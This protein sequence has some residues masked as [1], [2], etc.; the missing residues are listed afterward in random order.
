MKI[1]VLSLL[2]L[3]DV[4]MT[5]PTF[6]GIREKYP[7]AELHVLMNQQFKSVEPLIPFVDEFKYF[8]RNQLQKG[9]GEAN[10]NIFDSFERLSLLINELNAEKYDLV[11]NLTHNYLSAWLMGLIE[12][13]SGKIGLEFDEFKKTHLNSTWFE[14]FNQHS[15]KYSPALFHFSDVYYYGSQLP[16]KYHP[17]TLQETERGKKEALPY[18][19]DQYI[20][21]QPL[22][23]TDDKNWGLDKFSEALEHFNRFFPSCKIVLLGAPFEKDQLMELSMRL[24]SSCTTHQVALLSLEGALSLVK[25]ASLLLTLDT[26]IKHFASAVGTKILELVIGVSNFFETGAYGNGHV[27]V[28]SQKFCEQKN[29]PGQKYYAKDIPPALI[30][31]VMRAFLENDQ[32]QLGLLASEWQQEVSIFR[33]KIDE[34][35]LWQAQVLSHNENDDDLYSPDRKLW[36]SRLLKGAAHCSQYLG[37]EKCL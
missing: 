24:N 6:S 33:T 27:I 35:G 26:S 36:R 16:T 14:F 11:I 7:D 1:L 22:T 19:A 23:S 15:Q 20:V 30:A 25:K 37:E 29:K 8:D 31:I 9:L 13:Q 28:R 3:G 34:S 5:T 32:F 17:F 21:V 18:Q 4:V 2:R 12:S 10:R